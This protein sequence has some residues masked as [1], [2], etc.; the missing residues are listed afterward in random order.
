MS[1]GGDFV[2]LIA[3]SMSPSRMEAPDAINRR[4]DTMRGALSI[5]PIDVYREFTNSDGSEI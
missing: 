5:D 4:L 3:N 1:R 2:G